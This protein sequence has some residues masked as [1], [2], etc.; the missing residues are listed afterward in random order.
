MI[1]LPKAEAEQ[2][3]RNVMKLCSNYLIQ[4]HIEQLARTFAGSVLNEI[5]SAADNLSHVTSGTKESKDAIA[6]YVEKCGKGEP[7]GDSILVAVDDT[8]VELM[9]A[10]MKLS[11]ATGAL[12]EAIRF[13]AVYGKNLEK[14]EIKELLGNAIQ[15]ICMLC[16]KLNIQFIDALVLNFKQLK[17]LHPGTF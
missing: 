3:L 13:N 5:T 8:H 16:N 10:V 17:E 4:P 12:S 6:S 15:A 1:E 2:N 11:S 14:F 7:D 9:N